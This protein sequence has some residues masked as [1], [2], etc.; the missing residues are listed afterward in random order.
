VVFQGINA[1]FRT[2][3]HRAA[4]EEFGKAAAGVSLHDKAVMAR[5]RDTL[6]AVVGEHGWLD[7]CGVAA[8]FHFI[9]RVVDLLGQKSLTM[10]YS[11]VA[12]Q[13]W[14]WVLGA[15]CASAAAAAACYF[16]R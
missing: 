4:L 2:I 6:T 13:W 8:N 11:R 3:E 10:S 12:I 5:W 15:V 1:G 16:T 9:T 14:P 7:A